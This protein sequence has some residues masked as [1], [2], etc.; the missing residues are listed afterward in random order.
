MAWMNQEKKAKIASA[1]KEIMPKNWKYSLR[2]DHHSTIILTINQADI[3]LLGTDP[4][5]LKEGYRDINRYY[6]EKHFSGKTLDLFK[7]IIMAL[8]IDNYDN[9]DIMTDY[10]DVGHYVNI[11]IGRFDKPFINTSIAV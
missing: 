7:K 2:V 1:L 8:N 5:A 9:S 11:K 6:P 3:N 4:Y 10:F